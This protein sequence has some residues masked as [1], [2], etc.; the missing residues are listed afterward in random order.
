M[1]H[2]DYIFFTGKGNKDVT[3]FYVKVYDTLIWSKSIT[4]IVI[5]FSFIM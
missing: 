2:V 3:G 5:R 4:V 1:V